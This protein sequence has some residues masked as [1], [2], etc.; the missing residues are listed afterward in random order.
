MTLCRMF[1]NS[2]IK[3]FIWRVGAN[4]VKQR[5]ILNLD[6]AYTGWILW[7]LGNYAKDWNHHISIFKCIIWKTNKQNHKLD[8]FQWIQ[9]PSPKYLDDQAK[10][11]WLKKMLLWKKL[12]SVRNIA[13]FFQNRLPIG[14]FFLCVIKFFADGNLPLN[15]SLFYYFWKVILLC[16]S[17]IFHKFSSPKSVTIIFL[18]NFDSFDPIAQEQFDQNWFELVPPWKDMNVYIGRV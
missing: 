18:C 6:L 17:K 10:S 1:Q 4:V 15:S 8:I 5:K 9:S 16:V 13:I 11:F 2:G 14:S 7:L 12:I 3:T